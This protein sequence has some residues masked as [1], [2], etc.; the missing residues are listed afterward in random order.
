MNRLFIANRGEIAARII[1]TAGR[2]GIETV[3][4]YV[5]AERRAPFRALA[6]YDAL[7]PPGG[8]LDP[9]LMI[10]VAKKYGADALHPG[11]GFL[12]ERAEFAA[13]VEKSVLTFVGP[14]AESMRALGE[15]SAARQLATS[16]GVPVSTGYDGADQSDGA[17]SDAARVIGFPLLIKAAEGGGGRGMRLVQSEAEL[18]EQ[19]ASARREALAGFGDGKLLL[20]RFFSGGRHVE[21]QVIGDGTGKAAHLFERDC[22][23]QRRYQKLIEE[24]PAPGLSTEL[25]E[26]LFKASVRIAESA[27]L[28]GVA[29]VKFLLS[30]ER[31]EFVFMEVNT[32]LQVE[33]PVTEEI[34]GVDLVELQLRVASGEKLSALKLPAACSGHAIEARIVAEDPLNGFRPS[35]GVIDR[36]ALPAAARVEH[37]LMPG[38][39]VGSEFDSLLAKIIAHGKSREQAIERLSAAVSETVISGVQ[40]NLLFVRQLLATD[41]FRN[42]VDLHTAIEKVMNVAEDDRE[43]A[44]GAL[45]SSLQGRFSRQKVAGVRWKRFP[46]EVYAVTLRGSEIR[47]AVQVE[48]VDGAFAVSI[49]G[50]LAEP[51]YRDSIS[52]LSA[53]SIRRIYPEPPRVEGAGGPG[54]KVIAPLPGRIAALRVKAGDPVSEG[55]ILVILE[56]MK[57]EHAVRAPAGGKVQS[58][59]IKVGEIVQARQVLVE[60]ESLKAA[61]RAVLG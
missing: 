54:Q 29:T 49:D 39:V 9:E 23:V 7:I 60:L 41:E 27:N 19:L 50:S 47:F 30:S 33:H 10:E 17:L 12:S 31:G 16:L 8:Y 13:L 43:Q 25:R 24:A 2:L 57:M 22:T 20:E 26:K 56:S 21:V 15:K 36:L 46:A 1:R 44:K 28:R 40:T 51:K 11:Y 6:T 59:N 37:D 34:T 14:T 45:V 53:D 18:V 52:P 55:D 42:A 5:P 61:I 48:V 4:P 3:V 58:C 32:R 38:T 35:F